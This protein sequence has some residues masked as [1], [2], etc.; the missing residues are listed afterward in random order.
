MKVVVITAYA[1]VDTAVEA[2]KRGAFDY[3]AKP[4]TPAQVSAITRKVEEVRA[5]EA[6]LQSLASAKASLPGEVE[7]SSSSPSMQRA[8]SRARQVAASDATVLIRGESGTGKGVLARAI[9]EW[10]P[11][12]AK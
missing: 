7:L 10:S 12:A 9:H 6:K 11:R 8:V 1:T 4:F 5:L 2:M 3:L